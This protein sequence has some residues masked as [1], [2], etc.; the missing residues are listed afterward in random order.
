M[1]SINTIFK[2]VEDP[3]SF[4]GMPWLQEKL[5]RPEAQPV[6]KLFVETSLFT[7]SGLMERSVVAGAKS[8]GSGFNCA[9]MLLGYAWSR[10]VLQTGACQKSHLTLLKSLMHS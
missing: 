2:M 8:T 1:L 5:K 3:T 10:V 7:Q 9:G 4:L 6:R